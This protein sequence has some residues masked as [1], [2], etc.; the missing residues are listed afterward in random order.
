MSTYSI[1]QF[2]EI[3]GITKFV[4]RTWENRYGFLKPERSDTNI[5]IYTDEMLVRALNTNFLLKNNYKISKVSKLNDNE[6]IAEIDSLIDDKL[7]NVIEFYINEIIISAINFDGQKFHDTYNEGIQKFGLVN[8]Y[9]D[10]ILVTMK[11]I[12]L[13]WLSN[14]VSPSQEHFLSEQIKQKISVSINDAYYKNQ[15]GK[16]WLLFLPENE[17]HEIGLLFTKFLLVQNGNNVVYLGSNVPYGTL[18]DVIEKKNI[19]ATL[20]FAVTNGS[21]NNLSYTANYLNSVFNDSEH[22]VITHDLNIDRN[23][24]SNLKIFDNIDNFIKEISNK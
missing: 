5:R 12:G 15:S 21:K 1:N 16:T 23:L 4:L 8:F 10:V 3:T 2:S 6:I 18:I 13:L 11:K 24:I 20:L 9:R 17:F 22:Y 19:D 7:D 14:K